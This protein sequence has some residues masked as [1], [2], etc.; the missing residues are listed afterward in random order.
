MKELE[1]YTFVLGRDLLSKRLENIEND[2]AYK[3]CKR[4]ANAFLKSIEYKNY[5]QSGYDS[6]EN[7]IDNNYTI[8]STIILNTKKGV[9]CKVYYDL[10]EN[11]FLDAM[12][13]R[14]LLIKEELYDI[15]YNLDMFQKKE[16]DV[17][18]KLEELEELNSL[19]IDEVQRRLEDYWNYTINKIEL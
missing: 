1:Y 5:T 11:K 4:I 16:M 14:N 3:I 10:D 18:L 19:H 9:P 17:F 7:F 13:L 15:Y 8:I 6:L 12:N 2:I